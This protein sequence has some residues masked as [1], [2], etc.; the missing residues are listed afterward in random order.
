MHTSLGSTSTRQAYCSSHDAIQ[1][2]SSSVAT[3]R[4]KWPVPQNKWP[5][6][7]LD[8]AFPLGVNHT[9]K[10][11]GRTAHACSLATLLPDGA[12]C[13]RGS[14]RATAVITGSNSSALK[15]AEMKILNEVQ[16]ESIKDIHDL[17]NLL[18]WAKRF[19]NLIKVH[20]VHVRYCLH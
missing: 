14:Y 19:R 9:L 2:P 8:Q 15:C 10:H 12:A 5:V 16:F 6:L 4:K 3:E 17:Q 7:L 13:I 11:S 20:G 18:A 1:P